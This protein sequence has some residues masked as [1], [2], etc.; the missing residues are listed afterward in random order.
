MKI[1]VPREVINYFWE[2]PPEE[3]W[4]F[5]AFRWPVRVEVG[6]PIHFYCDESLIA[7]AVIAKIEKPGQSECEKTGKYKNM[8]K[9]YWENDSFKDERG[10]L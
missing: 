4:E 8:W 2:E 7:S 10:R 5:W 6:D 9:V 1:N 3:N